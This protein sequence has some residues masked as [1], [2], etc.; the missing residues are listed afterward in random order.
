[1]TAEA[2]YQQWFIWLSVAAV[3]VLAAA[4]LL[5]TIFVLARQ[6]ATAAAN[7]LSI[8]EDIEQNTQP[9]WQLNS[10][11]ETAGE[12]LSA[13]RMI[14]AGSATIVDALSAADR[15]RAV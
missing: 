15:Q 11:N 10:T 2:I 13:T 3:I 6:I 8:V 5:I 9:I 4:A 12:L 14:R 1:M 7:A